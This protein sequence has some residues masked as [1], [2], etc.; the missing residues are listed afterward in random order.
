MT[1]FAVGALIFGLY[2]IT[3]N[4]RDY[5]RILNP[6]RQPAK[7]SADAL[8]QTAMA[9]EEDTSLAD[10][11]GEATVHAQAGEPVQQAEER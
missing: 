2:V 11:N 4:W 1:A 3:A 7:A 6:R 5:G 9:P 8:L 10:G